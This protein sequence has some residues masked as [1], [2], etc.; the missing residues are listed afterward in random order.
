[1]QSRRHGALTETRKYLDR[2]FQNHPD[3]VRAHL[4]HG[5]VLAGEERYEDAVKAYEQACHCDVEFVPELLPHL[6]A[7]C[8]RTG[9]NDRAEAFLR[10]LLDSYQGISPVLALYRLIRQRDGEEEAVDFLTSQLHQR[11]SV[12]GL[13]TLIEA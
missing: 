9:Q 5:H 8:A 1:E 4:L 11:P 12:R 10:Q 3:S 7:A 13:T 2:A 6:L